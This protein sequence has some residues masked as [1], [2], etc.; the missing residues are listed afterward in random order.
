MT[1]NHLRENKYGIIEDSSTVSGYMENC[2]TCRMRRGPNLQQKM[3]NMSPKRLT[4]NHL[5]LIVGV[6]MSLF[7]MFLL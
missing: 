3:A 5:S 4:Q 1:H 2:F 7:N 6:T